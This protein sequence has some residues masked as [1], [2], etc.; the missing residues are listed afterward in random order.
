MQIFD[1]SLTIHSSM[2]V[3]RGDPPVSIKVEATV[4]NDGYRQS[5][6][7]LTTHTGTHIDAPSHFVKGGVGIDKIDLGKL[8]G[9]CKVID[10][11]NLTRKEILPEDFKDPIKKGDRIL[12][13]TGNFKLLKESSFPDEYISLSKEAAEFLVSRE[14]NLVGVD[15]LGIEKEKN[16]GHPVHLTLLK[17]GIVNVEGLDLSEIS[18][19]EYEIVCL[20][21][22]ILDGDGAPARV[23][24]IKR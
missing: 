24:L 8:I 4:E 16:P 9:P 19:G 7:S 10:L 21:L 15:F 18:E 1:I 3:W 11:T 6:L 20:P 14:I 12:L 13:R 22:K 23:I 2:L 17:A 5:S